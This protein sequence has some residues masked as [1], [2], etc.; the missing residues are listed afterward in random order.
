MCSYQNIISDFL[1]VK[2]A[3]KGGHLTSKSGAHSPKKVTESFTSQYL[4][5]TTQATGDLAHLEPYLD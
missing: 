4:R 1:R 5:Y 3:T 2:V